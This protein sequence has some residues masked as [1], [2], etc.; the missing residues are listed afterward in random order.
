M[1]QNE[2]PEVRHPNHFMKVNNFNE[3]LAVKITNGV[4]TMWC[5]YA[6]FILDLLMLPPVIA[7]QSILVWVTY[8]AQTVLQLVLLPI[9]IVGQ[10]VIQ[11]HNEAKADADY[12]TLLHIART[13]D[14]IKM[15]QEG[16]GCDRKH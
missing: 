5:A 3:R 7:S 2:H 6:F 1:Q 15:K 16:K 14:E 13:V 9:I 4:G 8:L 10:N 12:K 11:S